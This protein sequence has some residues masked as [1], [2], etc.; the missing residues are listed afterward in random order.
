MIKTYS[1]LLIIFSIFVI[2]SFFYLTASSFQYATATELSPS[3]EDVRSFSEGGF[4][5]VDTF[6]KFVALLVD[7]LSLNETQVTQVITSM[8]TTTVSSTTNY[9]LNHGME[10]QQSGINKPLYWGGGAQSSIKN[11]KFYSAS[12]NDAH[13]GKYYAR[14]EAPANQKGWVWV[15]QPG[16]FIDVSG[17]NQVEYSAYVRYSRVKNVSLEMKEYDT[18][19]KEIKRQVS[20]RI[21]TGVWKWHESKHVFNLS[22]ETRKVTFAVIAESAN[23]TGSGTLYLD[24]DDGF[25]KK[26]S[27]NEKIVR[28]NQKVA[29]SA[30]N[31][32]SPDV[33]L[34]NGKRQVY[35]SGWVDANQVNDGVYRMLCGNLGESCGT[36]VKVIDALSNGF[37]H[38]ADPSIVAMPGGYYIMYTTNVLRGEDGFELESNKIYYSTS[39]LS[40]GVNWSKPKLL[41][42]GV[43]L[44]SA[45]IG[46]TGYPE[47]YA[48]DMRFHGNIVRYALGETGIVANR[49]TTVKFS[50]SGVYLNADVKYRPSIKLYQMLAERM[51]SKSI[52]YLT[53]TDGINFT[54]QAE[55]VVTSESAGTRFVRTP[56]QDPE[57]ANWMYYGATD[58]AS[59]L[60][61]KIMFQTWE[62]RP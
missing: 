55:G 46:I 27:T 14:L 1:R 43:W 62:L 38:V 5:A 39:W 13:S 34:Q 29:Y 44:P 12:W 49:W 61:N 16:R 57:T 11:V 17:F 6:K 4:D 56:G 30:I 35:F 45:T 48:N 47:L 24:V 20:P 59:A 53:S 25:V 31:I 18:S 58:S 26:V 3:S 9:L 32:Y 41:A 10:A 40:D 51:D 54:L 7:L 15:N 23:L 33:V 36:P 50:N 21:G 22:P 28:S 2:T 37:E 42:E 60:E 19:G 52:D 8:G